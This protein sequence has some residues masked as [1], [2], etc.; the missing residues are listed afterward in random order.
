ML[1]PQ[2]L[3]AVSARLKTLPSYQASANVSQTSGRSF[4]DSLESDGKIQDTSFLGSAK[5]IIKKR[6]EKMGEI[7]DRDQSLGS[8]VFQTVGNA[9]GALTDI[10][11]EGLKRVTPEAIKEPIKAGIKKIAEKETIQGVLA[12]YDSWK[13]Q[14][15]EAAANLEATVDIASILPSTKI[16][17]L[18]IK[19]AEKATAKVG[20][21]LI[22]GAEKSIAQRTKDFALKLVKPL[23]TKETKLAD[24]SR[25]TETGVGPFKRSVIEP[26][27]DE[28]AMATVVEKV[29]GVHPNKTFQQ[30]YNV[31]SNYV[32][33]KVQA[34]K[35]EV[36]SYKIAIPKKET[37]SKLNQV[38]D[39]LSA[40]PV[41]VGDAEK[42]ANKLL[43]GAKKFVNKNPGSAEGVF[44]A[45]IDYDNWVK[46]QKPTA[47]DPK[48]E[49]AFTIA[50]REIRNTLNDIVD[51]K[52]PNV[53]T[54]AKRLEQHQLINSLDVI[55]SKAALEANT[56]I[57]RGLQNIGRVLSTKSKA[58]QALAAAVGIGGLGAAA[59]FAPGVAAVGVPSYF[60]YKGGKLIMKPEFR[61]AIGKTLVKSSKIL[62]TLNDPVEITAVKEFNDTLKQYLK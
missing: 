52:I 20:E 10:G 30:N 61:N 40:S 1:S 5:D 21:K 14:H 35:Q 17:G 56:A 58:V 26:S 36:S 39:T 7:V 55:E 60:I 18:G 44:Q 45:R 25:T 4:L 32:S 12:N 38:L 53:K 6:S 24:V 11:M 50:N 37:L 62:K 29:P 3:S 27:T 41:I 16:A 47:F 28:K 23:E 57:G 9:A 33:K 46:S 51:T 8:K 15:P 31:I 54:K 34:L 59:T 42:T 2:E 19:S 13:Q 48:A 43:E 22:S 49:N